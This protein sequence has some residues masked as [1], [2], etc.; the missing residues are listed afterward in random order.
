MIDVAND[1]LHGNDRGLP[2]SQTAPCTPLEL[3]QYVDRLIAVGQE[4]LNNGLTPIY[5]GIPHWDDAGLQLFA[6]LFGFPWVIDEATVNQLR[7]IL[8]AK[9][10]A[11]LPQAIYVDAWDDFE[12]LGDGLHPTPEVA[13]KAAERILDAIAQYESQ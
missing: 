13:E 5:T 3:V 7:S 6:Q 11:E 4:A 12:D 9:L 1:C 8:I 2:W 10:N